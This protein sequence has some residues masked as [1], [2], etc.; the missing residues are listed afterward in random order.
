MFIYEDREKV[1]ELSPAFA[2]ASTRAGT[3]TGSALSHPTAFRQSRASRE[4]I[5][6]RVTILNQSSGLI[7]VP[8][9]FF[10]A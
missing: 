6:V 10:G 4:R 1:R 9:R 7:V 2:T 8:C 5:S 3:K